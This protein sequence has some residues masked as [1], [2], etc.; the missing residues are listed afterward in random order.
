MD[1]KDFVSQ[2][3]VQIVQGVAD[4]AGPIAALGGFVSPAHSSKIEGSVVG[5]T[6]DGT[7]RWVHA[8]QFD[9]AVVAENDASVAGGGGLKVMG[10]NLGG[11]ASTRD[12]EQTTSRIQFV[13][14][15]ALPVD[16]VSQDATNKHRDKQ[17]AAL[18]RHR[19]HY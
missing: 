2:T 16:P 5:H 3:L 8:V 7:V 11:S 6:T 18:N 4:A 14:P 17:N 12:K 13:V 10:L 19:G 9:V 15:L 1:L